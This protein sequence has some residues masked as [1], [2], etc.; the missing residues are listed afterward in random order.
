MGGTRPRLNQT[1]E[2]VIGHRLPNENVFICIGVYID[3]LLHI[4]LGLVFHGLRLLASFLESD[5][6]PPF[7]FRRKYI[8]LNTPL[9]GLESSLQLV[10]LGCETFSIL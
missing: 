2:V 1:K 6:P 4:P 8:H 5:G 3:I 7:V 9:G 10:E